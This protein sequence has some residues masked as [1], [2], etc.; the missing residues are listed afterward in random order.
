MLVF[1]DI[2]IYTIVLPAAPAVLGAVPSNLLIFETHTI[3]SNMY[4]RVVFAWC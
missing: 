4:E 2:T 1:F 3:L